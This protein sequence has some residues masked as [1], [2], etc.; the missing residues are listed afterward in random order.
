MTGESVLTLHGKRSTSDAF[1]HAY[2]VHCIGIS[3]LP[4][5]NAPSTPMEF[6]TM[7]LFGLSWATTTLHAT[8]LTKMLL[9]R[10]GHVAQILF[11]KRSRMSEP[12]SPCE[13]GRIFLCGQG[14]TR[15]RGRVNV[16]V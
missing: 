1:V 3:G 11:V 13:N 10:L 15:G 16:F 6:S 5:V 8:D 9:S 4:E 12:S 7:P 14:R 2:N